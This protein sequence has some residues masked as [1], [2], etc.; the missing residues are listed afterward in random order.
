VI[1][2]VIVLNADFGRVMIEAVTGPHQN[3]LCFFVTFFAQAKKVK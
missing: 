2:A 1:D 3:R